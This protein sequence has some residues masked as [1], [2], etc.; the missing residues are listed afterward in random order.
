M[1]ALALLLPAAAALRSCGGGG[2]TL[3][4]QSSSSRQQQ[5]THAAPSASRT[6]LGSKLDVAAQCMRREPLQPAQPSQ[7]QPQPSQQAASHARFDDLPDAAG[8][9]LFGVWHSESQHEAAE[10]VWRHRPAIVAVETAVTT[11]HGAVTGAVLSADDYAQQQRD[12]R[13]RMFC[14]ISAQLDTSQPPESS[15]VW[16]V[17]P[18]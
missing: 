8:V 7:A 10:F 13:L 11:Q 2:G 4:A 5:H 16:Q 1:P 15:N 18:S 14:Q 12:F 3:P 9:H 6:Q 17:S